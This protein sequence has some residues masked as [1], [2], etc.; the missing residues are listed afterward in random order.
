[1]REIPGKA[2]Q[3]VWEFTL[4]QYPVKDLQIISSTP[5]YHRKYELEFKINIKETNQ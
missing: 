5:N 4:D 1:M 3:S 2:N